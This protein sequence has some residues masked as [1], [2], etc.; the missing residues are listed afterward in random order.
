MHE[1]S[2][3]ESIGRVGREQG[4]AVDTCEMRVECLGEKGGK[5]ERK[6]ERTKLSPINITEVSLDARCGWNLPPRRVFLYSLLFVH[7]VHP[8]FIKLTSHSRKRSRIDAIVTQRV[9]VIISRANETLL[10]GHP[11]SLSLF[12]SRFLPYSLSRELEWIT[13]VQSGMSCRCSNPVIME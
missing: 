12:S 1:K 5:R 6:R 9:R 13:T 8:P 7:Q 3:E 4:L 10:P 2:S 11:L